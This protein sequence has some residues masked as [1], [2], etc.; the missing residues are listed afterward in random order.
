MQEKVIDLG[1]ALVKFENITNDHH[2]GNFNKV[3][4]NYDRLMD[5]LE[6]IVINY[7]HI[8]SSVYRLPDTLIIIEDRSYENTYLAFDF[9]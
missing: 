9:I 4:A 7:Y 8:D 5:H 2:F 6:V 1:G 3:S